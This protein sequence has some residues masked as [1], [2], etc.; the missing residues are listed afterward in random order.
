MPACVQHSRGARACRGMHRVGGHGV[1]LLPPLALDRNGAAMGAQEAAL[2]Q[3]C[4]RK[5]GMLAAG[6]GALERN[7]KEYLRAPGLRYCSRR[8]TSAIIHVCYTTTARSVHGRAHW[9]GTCSGTSSPRGLPACTMLRVLIECERTPALLG[10]SIETAARAV[11]ARQV[12]LLPY[13][14]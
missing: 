3:A 7:H 5:A 14:R 8:G 9:R 4:Q 1:V 11:P 12:S 13:P 10:V 6:P 2:T